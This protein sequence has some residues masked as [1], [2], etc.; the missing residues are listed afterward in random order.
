[1]YRIFSDEF[2]IVDVN[3]REMESAVRFYKDMRRAVDAF[4]E[5]N[6]YQAV[7]TI[8]GGILDTKKIKGDYDTW[9]KLSEFALT[10]AKEAG[11]NRCCVFDEA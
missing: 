9:M 7:F 3:H 1:M 10:E 4:V 11:K 6:G 2:M 5:S 8:S